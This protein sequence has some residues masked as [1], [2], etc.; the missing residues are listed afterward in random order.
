[1]P[2]IKQQ[3]IEFSKVEMENVKGT[4]K[5]VVIGKDQGWRENSLRIFSISPGGHTPHHQ[6]DWEHVNYVLKGRG[7]LK[8]GEDVHEL[9]TG[10]Y[11][12]VPPNIIHQY[13]NNY[14]EDFEF[15]CIVPEK[16][17]Y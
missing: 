3:D 6:H 1:M 17:A 16:G 12:F 9:K 11:A 2:V 10:D 14:D 13:Q 15:I 7:Q 4:T 8:I 5:A